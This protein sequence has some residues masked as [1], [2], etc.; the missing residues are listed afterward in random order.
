LRPARSTTSATTSSASTTTR[1]SRRIRSST[2]TSSCSRRRT[3]SCSPTGP[4]APP[5]TRPA[6]P[7]GVRAAL[8]MGA[9]REFLLKTGWF[10][11]GN[12][13]ISSFDSRLAWTYNPQV[14]YRKMYPFDPTRAKALLDQA[15]F[16][17]GADG[18]RFTL[19]FVVS[20]AQQ[21]YVATSQAVKSMWGNVGINVKVEGVDQG[22]MVQRGFKA[23]KFDGAR[24]GYTTY[25]D[26]A[27]GIVRQFVS[28][29]I[30]QPF[31]NASGY[32]NPEVDQLG[33][34]GPEPTRQRV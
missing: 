20:S 25:G 21:P 9:D 11:I 34:P 14:D 4:G 33:A 17:P 23:G 19:E 30:G 31:G 24:Q 27:L 29:T 2:S 13:G 5:P 22:A 1:S 32:S 16:K 7:P 15:G 12:P 8:G 6:A 28:S 10:G 3:T 26:P 18:S